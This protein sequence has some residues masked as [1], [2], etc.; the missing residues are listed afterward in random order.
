MYLLSKSVCES[1]E[2][3]EVVRLHV[4]NRSRCIF[5]KFTPS[6]FEWVYVNFI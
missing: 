3:M 5:C 1:L 4:I 2:W 6:S